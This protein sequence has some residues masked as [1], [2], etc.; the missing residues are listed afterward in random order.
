M[1]R[2][3]NSISEGTFMG[4]VIQAGSVTV[5]LPSGP[6]P[7]LGI[8]SVPSAIFVGRDHELRVLSETLGP[9]GEDGSRPRVALV[10]GPAGVG[11]SEL[12]LQ[13]AD[14]AVG[15]GWFPG[16]VLSINLEGHTSGLAPLTAGAALGRLLHRLGLPLDAIPEHVEDRA[17]VYRECLRNR[18][19]LVILDNTRDSA[20][21]HPLL[22]PQG[23]AALVSSRNRLPALDDVLRLPLS[24]LSSEASCE[25]FHEAASPHTETDAE[26]T[27]ARSHAQRI[28]AHCG[29]LPLAL[30]VAAAR[31][32]G[33]APELLAELAEWLDDDR[34][35]LVE[36]DDGER[37]VTA[38]FRASYD[39]LDEEQRLLFTLCG[40][41]PGPRVGLH[42]VAALADLPLS[43]VRRRM[44]ILCNAHLADTDGAGHYKLHDLLH[45]YARERA[46]EDL[47]E[48]VTREAL[49]RLIDC[50]L[51][52]ADRADQAV[53]PGRYRLPHTVD[54]PPHSIADVGD[55][56]AALTWFADE[57]PQLSALLRT[58]A[59]T[60]D[61]SRCWI[62]ADAMRGFFFHAK[63]WDSWLETLQ[64]SLDAATDAGELRVQSILHN[65]MGVALIE[66]GRSQEAAHHYEAARSG[67]ESVGDPHGVATAVENRA[68]IHQYAGDYLAALADHQQALD[69][70][71]ALGARR[72]T[73]I[74]QRGMAVAERELGRYEDAA[75]HLT[76]ALDAFMEL[77]LDLDT[78][79][80]LNG[81]GEVYAKAGRA[82]PARR[83]FLVALRWSRACGSLFEEA[84]ARDG[85]AGLLAADDPR[86]AAHHWRRALAHYQTLSSPKA[87]KVR[88]RL[89]ALERS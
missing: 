85:L 63:A 35:R 82:E 72:N 33:E 62:M 47:P 28:A 80:A 11:K 76:Q 39:A 9:D 87:E 42:A 34:K 64:V 45:V 25:L 81:L 54:R 68:W 56:A 30:R 29:G 60:S 22:P 66:Q 21:V 50:Y 37:N 79:M 44:R 59:T 40:L 46:H 36:L 58:A 4:P 8:P 38:S 78:A 69:A 65:S 77:G 19:V 75:A 55:Q 67:F 7:H 31:V 48:E 5:H 24:P 16:G 71:R 27:A 10:T 57:L 15:R 74:V 49:D 23:S 61:P 51:Y 73:A 88:S 86:R 2:T 3:D 43:A 13:A 89:S 84:R 20:Q 26:R 52:T 17:A 6:A 32:R 70:Y 14:T 41:H 53:A 12:L 18:S 83:H 1:S